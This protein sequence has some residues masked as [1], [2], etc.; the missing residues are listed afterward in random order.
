[1]GAEHDRLLLAETSGRIVAATEQMGVAAEAADRIGWPELATRMRALAS[2]LSDLG[3]HV[4]EKLARPEP[5]PLSQGR[6]E[7]HV[8]PARHV[9]ED[10]AR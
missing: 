7:G 6:G 2:D 5:G 4:D 3:S 9:A 10:G 8:D 1:M